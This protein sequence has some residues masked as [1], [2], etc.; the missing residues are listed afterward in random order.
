MPLRPHRAKG[1]KR[2]GISQMHRTT[3]KPFA[4]DLFICLLALAG[5]PGF[6][7]GYFVIPAATRSTARHFRR[8]EIAGGL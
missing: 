5:A 8:P 1:L 4:T 6:L 2:K 3:P 7:N